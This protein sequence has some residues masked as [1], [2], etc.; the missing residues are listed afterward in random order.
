VTLVTKN[1]WKKGK[2]QFGAIHR[3]R[4]Y[5]FLGPEQQ[6]LFLENPDM[7]SPVLSGNDPVEFVDRG[8]LVQGKRKHGLEYGGQIYL[9]GSEANL[10]QFSR[11][12]RPYAI[13]VFQTMQQEP[14]GG[15]NR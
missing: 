8:R 15:A 11:S 3:G 10:E 5:L 1:E 9:F 12:P 13:R 2:P 7:L 14:S 4:T 6:K